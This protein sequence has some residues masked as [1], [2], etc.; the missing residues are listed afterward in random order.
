MGPTLCDTLCGHARGIGVELAAAAKETRRAVE[1]ANRRH[2]IIARA[3]A[4]PLWPLTALC[5][6]AL[7]LSV[8]GPRVAQALVA[9]GLWAERRRLRPVARAV[10]RGI[11]EGLARPR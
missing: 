7:A 8:L 4:H 3:G 9:G 5:G 2:R 6:G 11:A 1:E 10:E